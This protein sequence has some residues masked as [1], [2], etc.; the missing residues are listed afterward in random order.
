MW[1]FEDSGQVGLEAA[2]LYRKRNSSAVESF[3][4]E[5]GRDSSLLPIPHRTVNSGDRVAGRPV[6]EKAGL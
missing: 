5:N 1:E 3:R 2:T 6:R 4:R